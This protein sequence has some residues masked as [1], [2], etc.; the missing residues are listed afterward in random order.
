VLSTERIT[1]VSAAGDCCAAAF[2]SSLGRRW[3]KTGTF[4]N[5]HGES[6]LPH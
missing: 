4:E 6:A 1:H 3:V 2:Q 5:V